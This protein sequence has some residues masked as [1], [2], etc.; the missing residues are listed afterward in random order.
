MKPNRPERFYT[1]ELIPD[2]VIEKDRFRSLKTTAS[3][4]Y[5]L[6]NLLKGSESCVQR[7]AARVSDVRTTPLP[8]TTYV[9]YVIRLPC[10]ELYHSRFH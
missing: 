8:F 3:N 1:E 9:Q 5:I 6:Q 7:D 10:W 4:N 2:P